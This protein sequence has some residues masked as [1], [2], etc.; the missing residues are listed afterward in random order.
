[1]LKIMPMLRRLPKKAWIGI[2]ALTVLV[3]AAIIVV[4]IM[5]NKE[6]AYRTIKVH[7]IVGEAKVERGKEDI[8]NAYADMRLQSE[9]VVITSKESYLQLKL[10]DDKYILLEP[11][12]QIDIKATG[13][14]KDSKTQIKLRQGAIVNCVENGLSEKSEYK[15]ETPNSTI[16]I[17][18]TTFRVELAEDENGVTNTIVSCFEGKVVTRLVFPDGSLDEK[19]VEITSGLSVHIR[20]TS[21]TTVYVGSSAIDYKVLKLKVLEF[22]KLVIER[23]KKLSI[24]KEE[25]DVIIKQLDGG[26]SNNDS[27]DNT[28][29]EVNDGIGDDKDT[30]TGTNI[31]ANSGTDENDNENNNSES[32]SEI[33]D[34]NGDNKPNENDSADGNNSGSVEDEEDDSIN[35]SSD[36]NQNETDDSLTGD[37]S[38]DSIPGTEDDYAE[39][40]EVVPEGWCN[41]KF[42]YNGKTFANQQVKEGGKATRPKFKPAPAGDWDFDFSTVVNTDITVTWEE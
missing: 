10:D 5:S 14:K 36:N 25:L 38:D 8:I 22:L 13:D 35:D 17:R 30:D 42:V 9:D 4:I 24:T 12:T 7:D 6:E 28:D 27:E 16:A 21:E 40:P 39:E 34:S 2:G 20:G 41:V 33:E 37:N 3:I 15:I 32:N 23:G 29:N 1:M 31:G 18:G 26:D 11:E 19:E